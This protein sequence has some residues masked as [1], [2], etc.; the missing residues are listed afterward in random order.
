M[1]YLR[2]RSTSGSDRRYFLALSPLP[3]DAVSSGLANAY[4]KHKHMEDIRSQNI[5]SSQ[6]SLLQSSLFLLMPL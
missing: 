4:F 2:T 5:S 1:H 3:N 6:D